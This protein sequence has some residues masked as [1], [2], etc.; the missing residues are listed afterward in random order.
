MN[1]RVT[2]DWPVFGSTSAAIPDSTRSFPV[3]AGGSLSRY[4]YWPV[5]EFRF[6]PAPG[7]PADISQP[8]GSRFAGTPSTSVPAGCFPPL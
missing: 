4:Q 8:T 6:W 1:C 5:F 3:S 2:I 7:Q